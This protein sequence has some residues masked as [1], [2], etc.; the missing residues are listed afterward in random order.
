VVQFDSTDWDFLVCRAEANGQVV[1]VEDDKV[2]IFRPAA[3]SPAL[4]VAF[5]STVLEL[6][7]EMD[8]RWQDKGVKAI[9]W[10]PAD[11][12]LAEAD[13][14][15]PTVPAAGNVTAADLAKAVGDDVEELRHGGAVD[16]AELQAWADGRLQRMRLA[17]LRGRARCQGFAKLAPGKTVQ[18][19]GIGDRFA[20]KLFVSGVRHTVAGGN[21]ETDVQFGLSPETFAETY[22]L[23]PS[24]AAGLLPAAS[25]LQIGVV[26]ALENDPKGEERIRV[27]LPL[28]DPKE[29]GVWA[30]LATFSASKD[31]GAYFRP[32]IDDEVVVGFLQQDPDH[33]VVLGSCNSSARAS[34][35]PGKDDNNKKGWVSREKLK[36]TFD[37]DKKVVEL[38]TPGGNK[39]TLSDD[40]KGI[41]LVDQNGNKLTLDD[42]GITVESAKDMIFK[43]PSGDV[44]I[45]GKNAELT[46]QTG[47]KASGASTAEMSGAQTKINGD[48]IT[49]IKGG[50]VQIN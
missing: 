50:L 14:A 13:G 23:K 25:G 34:A 22:D 37:E 16:T 2:R 10:S 5:G 33:P 3:S 49:V 15:E 19:T 43:A 38:E 41:A 35:E 45:S 44:K 26:T 11:Q 36:L 8:A 46:A 27:R 48:A 42:K 6:D 7:A 47:F 17:R 1:S 31:H 32:E 40:A 29:D 28:V 24:P 30:R 4:Q 39:L 9:S 12:K 21:W 20:G 18:I